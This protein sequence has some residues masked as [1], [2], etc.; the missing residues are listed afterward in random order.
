MNNLKFLLFVFI[1][2]FVY[3]SCTKNGNEL[4]SSHTVNQSTFLVDKT[5]SDNMKSLGGV[6]GT[7]EF[8]FKDEDSNFE[9]CL[10]CPTEVI[11][12]GNGE[13]D[14]VYALTNAGPSMTNNTTF[15][16]SNDDYITDAFTNNND[17]ADYYFG[18]T[19]TDGVINGTYYVERIYD[20][21]NSKVYAVF[22]DGTDI[23]FAYEFGY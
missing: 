14:C 11:G 4:A 17:S 15:F 1:P 10:A 16:D 12:L 9:D 19:L 5:N 20:V 3:V 7:A 13:C 6:S 21:S 23:V 18:Q 2:T 8:V 22:D